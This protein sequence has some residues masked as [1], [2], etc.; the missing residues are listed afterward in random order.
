MRA[1]AMPF[2]WLP[3][4]VDESS[5]AGKPDAQDDPSEGAAIDGVESLA[6]STGTERASSR[7]ASLG[8]EL[9][10]A[11]IVHKGD[12]FSH[13]DARAISKWALKRETARTVV[14]DLSGADEAT[15]AAFA[16]LVLLRRAL[17]REGRDL[18]LTGLRSRTRHMYHVNRLDGVLPRHQPGASI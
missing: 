2:L 10:I 5:I 11:R 13:V 8:A 17:R 14:V 3:E 1:P 9:A 12:R 18:R 6:R 15:T 7:D 4:P 16:T